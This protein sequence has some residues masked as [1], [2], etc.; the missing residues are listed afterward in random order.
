[1]LANEIKEESRKLEFLHT[2]LVLSLF[3]VTPEEWKSAIR[4]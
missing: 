3:V 4:K 1:M 2:F